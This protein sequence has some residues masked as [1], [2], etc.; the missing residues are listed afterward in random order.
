VIWSPKN[1]LE[2]DENFIHL[3]DETALVLYDPELSVHKGSKIMNAV[4]LGA[5]TR[6]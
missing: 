2:P 1:G 3:R 6:R 5:E 4:L